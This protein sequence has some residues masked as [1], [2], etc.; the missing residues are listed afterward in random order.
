MATYRKYYTTSTDLI[1]TRCPFYE[2]VIGGYYCVNCTSFGQKD[3]KGGYVQCHK[4][5]GER[6]DALPPQ[7]K[8]KSTN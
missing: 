8:R 6:V 4:K 7:R 3:R 2:C 5:I 1:V